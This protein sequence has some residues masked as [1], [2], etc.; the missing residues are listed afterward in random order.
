MQK[1][2]DRVD[3]VIEFKGFNRIDTFCTSNDFVNFY[4]WIISAQLLHCGY[5]Q[6][7]LCFYVRLQYMFFHIL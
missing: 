4:K 5:P 1:H 6:T 3:R 2:S 7:H